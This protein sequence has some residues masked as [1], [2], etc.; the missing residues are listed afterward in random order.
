MSEDSLK[1]ILYGRTANVTLADGK[2]YILREPSI[3]T[4]ENLDIDLSKIDE[5]KNIKKLVWIL[6][7]ED[8]P[9]LS[10][11]QF[12]KLITFSMLGEDSPLMTAVLQILGKSE[13]GK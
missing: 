7:K 4:L 12:G 2:D 11:K 8:N 9:N 10:E 6:L 5:I 1:P 13:K 3:D